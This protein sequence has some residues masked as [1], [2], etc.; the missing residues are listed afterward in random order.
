MAPSLP[1]PPALRLNKVSRL[2]CLCGFWELSSAFPPFKA[3]ITDWAITLALLLRTDLSQL[4]TEVTFPFSCS[5]TLRIHGNTLPAACQQHL[6]KELL[7]GRL[8]RTGN[9]GSSL[10]Q[11]YETCYGMEEQV[12]HFGW[13][14]SH[15]FSSW[16]FESHHASNQLCKVHL[17]P[18]D[19][20][21][22]VI[23]LKL[24]FLESKPKRLLDFLT[25]RVM[26]LGWLACFF[27]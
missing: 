16:L 23:S 22:H 11:G 14:K 20:E 26:V 5:W 19:C 2:G 18:I 17:C 15:P 10:N 4:D 6:N 8:P 27:L 12:C 7:S 3:N 9:S 21:D 13:W 25:L 1:A 24:A